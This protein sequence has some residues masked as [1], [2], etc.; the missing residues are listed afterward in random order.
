MLL[1]IGVPA[2]VLLL[3]FLKWMF[4]TRAPNPFAQDSRRPP[5]P[6]VTEKLARQ[7]VLKQGFAVEKI[8]ENLDAVVIGSGIGGLGVAAVLAKAG[9]KVLVLEQHTKAGGCCHTFSEKGYEFDVGIHY[10][11]RMYENGPLRF[12]TD[13]LTDGQL[14]WEKMDSPFDTVILGDPSTGKKYPLYSGAKEYI[15]GL[16]KSFPAESKAIDKYMGLVKAVSGTT[17]HMVLIKAIPL[18]LAKFL[19]WTGLVNKLSPY[20]KMASKTVTQVV[21]E[22]TDNEE[23]RAVFAYIFGC[24]GVFPKD[25]SFTL[26]A[27]LID[28]YLEGGWY[29]VGGSSEIAFHLI[30]VIEKAGGAVLNKAPVQRIL[31]NSQ[32]KACGVSVQ[33]KGQALVNILAPI[34]ISDAGIFNTYEKLLP[35][36]VQS[37]PGIRS[38]LGMVKHGLA[39]I[40]LFLG[41]KGTKEELGLTASNYYLFPDKN[42]NKLKGN[43]LGASKE[44]AAA[45]VPSMYVASPSAKDPTWEQRFP[46]RSTVTV[47]TFAPY[48]WFEEWKDLNV[49][50]RG[51]DY[52]SLK[53][54][55]TESMLE[56]VT[57]LYPKIKDKIDC[58]SIGTPLT[59]QHYIAAPRGEWYGI[60]HDLDR[61][62]AEVTANIRAKTPI[63]NLYLT[64]QDVA[65]CGF[66]G[67]LLGAMICSS[68]ILDRNTYFDMDGLRKEA[69]RRRHKKMN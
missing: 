12:L 13:Q 6:L 2:A 46:G 16:K 29:P 37:L 9:K 3:L 59:N 55:F 50:K 43:Y 22:L 11:G 67:A 47:L 7:K 27:I 26:H 32:R 8:P 30:P 42:I 10:I 58:I 36:E 25:A 17:W 52:D 44:D 69:K 33:T 49:K 4:R 54:T 15:E 60:N 24:Y 64:G 38:Q 20:F 68:T 41:I 35:P 57:K 14:Q 28:H 53:N 63:E 40:S 48:E 45:H 61:L 31:L 62:S 34:V 56:T 39:G 65:L 19:I 5:A 18:P 1:Y 21:N 51:V 66:T 23:L